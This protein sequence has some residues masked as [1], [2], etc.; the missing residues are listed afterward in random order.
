MSKILKSLSEIDVLIKDSFKTL[1]KMFISLL[2]FNAYF[3]EN[4]KTINEKLTN[5]DENIKNIQIDLSKLK[6]TTK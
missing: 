2:Y 1:K 6:D 5:I 4:I 3:F